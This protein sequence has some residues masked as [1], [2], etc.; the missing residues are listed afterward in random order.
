[1][2]KHEAK[3][4]AERDDTRYGVYWTGESESGAGLAKVKGYRNATIFRKSCG[5]D[6]VILTASEIDRVHRGWR[7]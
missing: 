5:S 2:N 6:A 3:R 7:P 4:L 1:M